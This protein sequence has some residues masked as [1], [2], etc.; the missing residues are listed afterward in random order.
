MH[1]NTGILLKHES[2]SNLLYRIPDS[3]A[4]PDP[5]LID[6]VDPKIIPTEDVSKAFRVL[7]IHILFTST[8]SIF[9]WL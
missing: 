3:P 1:C 9:I 4:D 6:M 8:V 2:I 7:V 5:E